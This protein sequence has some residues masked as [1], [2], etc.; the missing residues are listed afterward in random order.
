MVDE[1]D[2]G[3]R[4]RR[5]SFLGSRTHPCPIRRRSIPFPKMQSMLRARDLVIMTTKT[6]VE[7][8]LH[9]AVVVVAGVAGGVLVE[10]G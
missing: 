9:L 10:V 8:T 6:G 3:K 2:E 4:Q 1:E 5:D 7:E